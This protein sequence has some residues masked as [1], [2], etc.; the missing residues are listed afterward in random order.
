M[1]IPKISR[2]LIVPILFGYKSNSGEETLRS[3][4]PA[5]N[6]WAQSNHFSFI[7]IIILV[8]ITP[9]PTFKDLCFKIKKNVPLFTN[10]LFQPKH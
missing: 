1:K 9:D 4:K 10:Q 2:T 7:I 6:F 5:L 3:Y 8:K